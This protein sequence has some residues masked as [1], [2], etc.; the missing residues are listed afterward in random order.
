MGGAQIST[1]HAN[2]ILNT[3]DATA[4]DVI[5]L[6]RIVKQKAKEVYDLDLKEEIF[7]VGNFD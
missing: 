3:G 4:A 6:I 7:Y 1:H 2:F 5:K